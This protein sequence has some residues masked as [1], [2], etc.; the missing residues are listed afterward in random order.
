MP[1]DIERIKKVKKAMDETKFDAFICR[2]PE[3]VLFLSGH[4]PLNG[5]SFLV[6]P[7]EGTPVLIVPECDGPEANEQVWEAEVLTFPFG[8]LSAG[9]PYVDIEKY[10][11]GLLKSR[12]MSWKNIGVE[13]GFEWVSPAANAAESAIPASITKA[14]LERVFSGRKVTDSSNVLTGLRSIKT[15]P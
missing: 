9:N 13:Q 14:L 6:F 5:F 2:L 7:L 12:G 3:N 1:T 15:P 10:L 4:W 11:C 8:T